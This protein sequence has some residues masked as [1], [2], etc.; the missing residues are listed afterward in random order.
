MTDAKDPGIDMDTWDASR[1]VL[2]GT[3]PLTVRI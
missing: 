2:S 1:R 3:L